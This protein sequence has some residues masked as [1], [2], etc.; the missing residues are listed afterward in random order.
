MLKLAVCDDEEKMRDAIGAQIA[1]YMRDHQRQAYSVTG[2]DSGEDLLRSDETFDIVFL[3]IQMQGR[4]GLET[5][6]RLRQQGFEGYIVFVTVLEEYVYDA[7]EVEASDYL[8]KPV[9]S[10]RFCR[11]MDRILSKRKGERGTVI[12]TVNGVYMVPFRDIVYCEVQGR[13]MHVHRLDGSVL[14]F[15]EKLTEFEQRLDGSF[16]K[17]HRSYLINLAHVRSTEDGT[18]A[19]TDGSR[20][21]LSRLREK[22]LSAALLRFMKSADGS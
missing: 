8:V 6:H 5:A 4:D 19:L 16:F 10:D 17:C 21:P 9:D 11:L 18:V 12:R 20:V 1:S 14:S 3:D 22:D 7:F 2:F 13:K 15:Y